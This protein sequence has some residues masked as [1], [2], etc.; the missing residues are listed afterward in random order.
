MSI[1]TEQKKLNRRDFIK[2]TAITGGALAGGKLLRAFHSED[3]FTANETCLLM[4]TVVNL[5]IVGTDKSTTQSAIADCFGRMERLEQV[6]SRFISTSQL[7]QLNRSGKLSNADPALLEVVSHAL[8]ISE[9]TQGAFDISIKP[10][11]DLYQE[12]QQ[13]EMSLPSDEAIADSLARV[14]YQRVLVDGHLITFKHPGMAITLDGIAKG[15]IVDM[16]VDI[17][18]AHGFTNVLVEAGGDMMG[19][20]SK[21]EQSPWKI[22]VQSPRESVGKLMAS[23]TIQEQAMATSGDY[24]QSFS[25]DLSHHHILDPRT[26]Y[27][28]PELASASVIAPTA[29]LADGLATAIMVMGSEEGLGLIESLSG[30]EAYLVAKDLDTYK[31]SGL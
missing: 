11:V 28:S 13:N 6:M 2:I 1:V 17:L 24:M 29:M 22:G 3:T 25:K 14:D 15:Y 5:T 16:G 12:N 10:L 4:G 30:I 27:S 19:A 8:Q 31:T 20:G 26:G 23:F 21:A 18:R 9:L 7:S